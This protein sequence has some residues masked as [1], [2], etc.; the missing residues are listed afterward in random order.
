M[1]YTSLILPHT[2][3]NGILKT[4]FNGENVF[5]VSGGIY[6]EATRIVTSGFV[7][8]D[9]LINGILPND[10]ISFESGLLV[11]A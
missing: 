3:I 4:A 8:K 2:Y 1:E 11:G 10:V 5:A 9:T 6:T 7:T